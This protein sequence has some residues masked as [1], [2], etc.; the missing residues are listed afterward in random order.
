M[1]LKV[2]ENLPIEVA[3][4]LRQAEHDA[5]TVQEQRLTGR[6]DAELADV[7]RAEGRM[8]VTLDTDFSKSWSE[9]WAQELDRRSAAIDRHE[10]ALEPWETVESRIRA[11]LRHQLKVDE[12]DPKA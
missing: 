12:N 2:D 8:L 4:A 10:E 3:E 9:A 1:K 11:D 7:C 6:P 5:L